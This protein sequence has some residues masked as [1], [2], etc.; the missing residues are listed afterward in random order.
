MN[1]RHALAREENVAT[2]LDTP[3]GNRLEN[4]QVE[5]C[6]QRCDEWLYPVENDIKLMGL[7][8]WKE[9]AQKLI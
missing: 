5:R 2:L 4:S 3:L 1:N 6:I 8:M 9:S 7:V